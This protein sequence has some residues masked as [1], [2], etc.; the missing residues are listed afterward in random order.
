MDQVVV[1]VHAFLFIAGSGIN[2]RPVGQHGTT[3]GGHVQ[4][5][6]MAFLALVVVEGSIGCLAGFFLIVRAPK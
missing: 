2:H 5:V 4:K 3:L 1:T 6:A